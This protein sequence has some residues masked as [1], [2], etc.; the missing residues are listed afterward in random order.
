MRVF[1]VFRD[2][3]YVSG[4]QT[5]LSMAAGVEAVDHAP[6]IAL[7]WESEALGEADVVVLDSDL[8]GAMAFVQEIAVQTGARVLLCMHEAGTA[9]VLDAIGSGVGGALS[10]DQL[11]PDTLL[12]A[13]NAVAAGI[14]VFD[15]GSVRRLSGSVPP[16]GQRDRVALQNGGFA[17]REQMVLSLVAA[18]L[19]NREIAERLSYSE[20]TIKTIL[21]DVVIRLGVKSRSQA[22]ALAV[23]EQII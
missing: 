19:S 22:V 21:H 12:A 1:I 14:F 5:T 6:S 17:P 13:V 16:V 23:R 20:R 3:I 9:A 18:G 7:A 15:S 2:T 10:R 4:L 11:T 8:G